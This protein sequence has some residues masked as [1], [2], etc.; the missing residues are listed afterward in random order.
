MQAPCFPWITSGQFLGPPKGLWVFLVAPISDKT[1]HSYGIFGFPCPRVP[2][3][4]K[5][6]L[7]LAVINVRHPECRRR[8]GIRSLTDESGFTLKARN[9][10]RPRKEEYTSMEGFV[11]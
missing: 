3:M 5:T 9:R 1:G 4:S 10:A 2:D 6:P 7:T 11:L 8:K